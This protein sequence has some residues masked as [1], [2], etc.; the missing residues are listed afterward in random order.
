M[1]HIKHGI[2]RDNLDMNV[3]PQTDFYE[4]ACGG[5]KKAHPIPAEHSRFGM[6]DLL[7]EENRK[8]LQKLVEGL[9]ENPDS[10]IK[11]TIAQ[12][13]SDLYA[14][15]LDMERRN[16]EGAAPLKAQLDKIAS[17]SR[18]DLAE[19]VAW[20]HNGI[21]S[22]FF[23]T[24]VGPDPKDSDI[25]IM[26]AGEG[27]L[28]LGDRDYYLVESDT[29]KKILDAYKV[30]I[31]RLM[32]LIGYDADT[33]SRVYENVMYIERTLALY[34]KTRE[35]RRDPTLSYNMRGYDDFK[36]E[37][38]FIDWDRY[39][40][41]L[42]VSDIKQINVGS[43]KYLK[44]MAEIMPGFSLESVKDYLTFQAVDGATGLLS[45]DFFNASFQ[46]YDVTM[47]GIEEP[48]PLWKR[49]LGIPGSML[50]HA[51]GQLYV[52]EYF[53]E[54]NKKYVSDL[55]ENLR[56]ALAS[57]IDGLEW[58]GESTKSAAAEKLAALRVKI[59]YPDKWK[60]YSEIHVDP[61]LPY[62]ENV[63]RASVWYVQDNYSKM[64]K[65][66]DR[67]EWFMHPQTVNAYYSPLTNEICFPAGILQPPYFDI[68]ADD[69]INYGAIGVV[70][71]HEMTHGFDDQGRRFDLSGNLKEWWS[72]EDAKRF[73][74]LADR[75]V[76]QFN[77]IEVAPGTFANGRYTLGENIADQGGLRVALSAYIRHLGYKEN[78]DVLRRL[79]NAD[80][81]DD[82][83]TPLQRFYMSYALLWAGNIRPE[84]ILVRTQTDPHSLGRYRVNATLSN[85]DS[86]Y[87]AFGVDTDWN[88]YRPESER[89]VIW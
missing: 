67:E 37:F 84:E 12:K 17:A 50:G 85:I 72:D 20:A 22:S 3:R 66:V 8:R 6:F 25:N 4:Y 77:A 5:W 82:G 18:D 42:G 88:L 11:D 21:T 53:P 2:D 60:D 13:V 49:A 69:A 80:D 14:Q 56:A 1:N 64:G 31:L 65:P 86:F 71:G 63:Y 57:H 45:D 16:R 19:L 55:V 34:K 75:L 41:V 89:T 29:N 40:A 52:A 43:L 61:S 62:L 70:I 32:E 10:K 23:S 36:R 48:E 68:T 26:H 51:I 58:M 79:N 47:S 33:A 76:D 44:A 59:G 54:E 83:F 30:Y 38:P 78:D 27:G 73:N 39:F 81:I 46:M 7:R 15:G 28:G 24:G 35:E 74:A 9:A 87:E